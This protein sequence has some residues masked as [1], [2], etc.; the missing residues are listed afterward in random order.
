MVKIEV[1]ICGVKTEEALEAAARGGA[2]YVGFNFYRPSPR[3]VPPAQA[4]ALAVLMRPGMK[5]A[6]VTVDADDA[7]FDDIFRHVE[8][9]LIQ[10]HGREPPQRAADL[11]ARWKRPIIR[12]IAIGAA[13]DFDAVT[14]Y[15][16]VADYFL[17]EAAPPEGAV[18]PGGNARSFDWTLLHGRRLATPWFLAGGL[19]AKNVREAITLSGATRVDLSSGVERAPGE[20]DPAMIEELLRGF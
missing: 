13:A 19:N 2:A 8:P 14:A 12:T 11:K 6:A 9:D 7:L 5:S 10:L 18:L 17:F 16:G 3:Y 4:A 1:K 20:K 15:D